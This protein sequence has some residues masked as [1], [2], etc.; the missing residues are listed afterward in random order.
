MELY[1]GS[2]VR[3]CDGTEPPSEHHKVTWIEHVMQHGVDTGEREI[4]LDGLDQ[5]YDA[6]QLELVPVVVDYNEYVAPIESIIG[7]LRGIADFAFEN[8]LHEMGYVPVDM[9]EQYL[10]RLHEPK[11]A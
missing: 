9:L 5:R 2:K 7:D 10:A 8:G 1:L 3:F 4:G 6:H 11:G